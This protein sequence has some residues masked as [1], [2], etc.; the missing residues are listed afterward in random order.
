MKRL[1]TALALATFIAGPAFAQQASDVLPP[2]AGSGV[3]A[4]PVV[5]ASRQMVV[6]ANPYAAEA[7]IAMLRAGGSAADALVAVQT[8]LGLVEPQSSGLGGGGFLTWYDATAK[9]LTTFDARET[10]PAAAT[11]QSVHG[12]RRQAA[13]LLRRGGRRPLGRRARHPAAARNRAQAF[14][15]E[16]LGRDCCS[17]QSIFRKTA[18]RFRRA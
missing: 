17:R 15:Q 14:R 9:S 1:F 13:R 8:V 5:H 16:A 18:S 7:G 10:A 12:S 4:K 11:P 3:Q 2:E 6:A